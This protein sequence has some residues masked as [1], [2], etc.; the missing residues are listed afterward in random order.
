M[1]KI[2]YSYTWAR[3]WKDLARIKSSSKTYTKALWMASGVHYIQWR[4]AYG[5]ETWIFFSFIWLYNEFYS[6]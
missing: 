4:A 5:L 1:H 2:S 3:L 6:C